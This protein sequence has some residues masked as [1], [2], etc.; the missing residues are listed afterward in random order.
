MLNTSAEVLHLNLAIHSGRR[1]DTAGAY[2]IPVLTGVPVTPTDCPPGQIIAV[3]RLADVVQD[4]PSR[5]YVG[6]GVLGWV[7]DAVVALP[8]PVPCRGAQGLWPIPEEQLR[9][10]REQWR[11]AREGIACG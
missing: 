3:A 7:L 1:W 9:Q 10:V 2:H 4:H 8:Q 5:W 6:D 11:M